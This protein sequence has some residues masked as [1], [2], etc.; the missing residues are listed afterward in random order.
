M[1]T[2]RLLFEQR[3]RRHVTDVFSRIVSPAV[4]T[5]LLSADSLALGGARK[6]I[7]I[8][9]ADVRGFTE[10]TDHTQAEAEAYVLAN[11]L[12]EKAAEEYYNRQAAETLKLVN[13]YLATI[14]DII[15][16]HN[17]TLDKYIGDCV[18]AFWGAP[19]DNPLHAVCC[20][21]AG[22]EAQKELKVLNEARAKINRERERINASPVP[23]QP[24]LPLLPILSVGTGINTG[25]A[26]VGLM[27][28]NAH[29]LN[30]TVF[31][32][33]VNVAARLEGVSGK[34]RII[35]SENTFKHL[36]RD[37][38]TLA[39]RCI[40]LEPVHVR[41][42]AAFVNIYEVLWD[43]EPDAVALGAVPPG[44]HA[45]PALA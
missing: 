10:F 45:Q 8:Y 44:A 12:D 38:P 5:D 43:K 18:M 16:K 27:G 21:R 1:L 6:E 34:N 25:R 2:Y 4:V 39:A 33:E 3:E 32:R 19:T 26:T 7:T 31:G 30:Y 20:V 22:I 23:P 17:G 14:A 24:P 35:I 13:T 11:K 42:I 41:G 29:I 9:F 15:K 28:S 36:K 40:P 37:D